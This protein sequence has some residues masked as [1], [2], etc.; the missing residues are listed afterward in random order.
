MT[1]PVLDIRWRATGSYVPLNASKAGLLDE[2]RQYL[3]TYARLGDIAATRR[4]LIDGGLP[5]R[6]RETRLTIVTVIQQRLLRWSPP[7]W[8]LDDLVTFAH[9]TYQPSLSAA[10]LL[11]VVRQDALLY[12][13]V[14]QLVAPRWES[15]EHT[16]VRADVQRFLDQA[17]PAHPEIAGWSHATRQKLAGNVLSILRDYGLLR[18]R[19]VKQIIEPLAPPPVVDHLLRLL[20]AEGVRD[21]ALITHPDW[22]I[23]LWDQRRIRAAYAA[24]VQEAAR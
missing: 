15:G 12:D 6:A 1:Q 21:E 13:F 2:T 11:H 23:W 5:Q 24:M 18:G 16:L 8:V 7:A 14:L 17:L 3:L 20:H 9:D 10:L 19:E 22:R 4:A